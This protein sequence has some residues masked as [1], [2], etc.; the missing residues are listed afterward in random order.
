MNSDQLTLFAEAAPA[1]PSA[2]QDLGKVFLTR[3]ENSCSHTELLQLIYG[4]PGLSGKTSPESFPVTEDVTLRVFWRCSQAGLSVSP[5]Q[6]GKIVALLGESL[7][8]TAL[9]GPAL[10]LSSSVF[11]NGASVSS[12]SDILETGD[13]PRRFYLSPRACLGI[14]RRA[15]RRGKQ[16]PMRLLQALQQVAEGSNGGAIAEDKTRSSPSTSMKTIRKTPE[17]PDLSKQQEPSTPNTEQGGV[18][19]R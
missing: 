18:T 11:R 2:W 4:L 6:A 8:P 12:L 17:S 10:T 7:K 14:L 19:P 5:H 1:R 16:L 3:A 9:P 13:V 15:E